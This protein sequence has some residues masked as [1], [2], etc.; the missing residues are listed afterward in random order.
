M[1][2]EE[3]YGRVYRIVASIPYGKVAT[4]GQIAWMLELPRNARQVGHALYSAPAY[5]HLPCHRVVNSS[6]R[7]VPGWPEQRE[8]LRA[9]G[10]CFKENGNVD[11]KQNIWNQE[12]QAPSNPLE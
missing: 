8:L 6:G 7:M 12:P 4:Y 5:L 9:E 10:V 2:R 3:F 1:N 11:L